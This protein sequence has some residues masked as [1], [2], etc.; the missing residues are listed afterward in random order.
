MCIYDVCARVC[1][2]T[3]N[4]PC[5]RTP[6]KGCEIY[7]SS[8]YH[9][10]IADENHHRVGQHCCVVRR[11]WTPSPIPCLFRVQPFDVRYGSRLALLSATPLE[12]TPSPYRPHKSM[13]FSR[14]NPC[15]TTRTTAARCIYIHELNVYVCTVF[16]DAD[17]SKKK[18]CRKRDMVFSGM[19]RC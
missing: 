15:T 19:W 9:F 3:L 2:N 14:R 10:H 6:W 7:V 17:K 16:P 12:N 4:L 8:L 13:R 11:W 5:P 1:V 18:I